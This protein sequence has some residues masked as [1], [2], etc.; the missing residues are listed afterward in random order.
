MSGMHMFLYTSWHC[1]IPAPA[2]TRPAPDEKCAEC[3]C[4]CILHDI[5]IFRHPLAPARHPVKM[6]A[7]GIFYHTR[8]RCDLIHPLLFI[9]LNKKKGYRTARWMEL[10]WRQGLLRILEGGA[11]SLPIR[12]HLMTS[13]R[14]ITSQSDQTEKHFLL[15]L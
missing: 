13:V 14:R 11:C 6:F 15:T 1:K 9:L 7:N 4:F 8:L 10:G 12:K 5:A 3:I 2:G